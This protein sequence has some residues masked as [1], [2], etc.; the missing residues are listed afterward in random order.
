MLLGNSSFRPVWV[1][2]ASFLAA[3]CLQILPTGWLG[4]YF[5]P[6]WVALVLI[7]WCFREPERMGPGV[8][9]CGGLLLDIV[10]GGILGRHALAKTIVGF[11]SHRI[12]LR[13]RTYPLWQQSIAVAFLI[14]VDTLIQ[15][16]VRFLI[17]EPMMPLAGWLT[18]LASMLMWPLMV[19]ILDHRQR[20]RR[21]R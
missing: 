3:A 7:Y 5:Q 12:S 4:G 6:D 20:S 10:Q 9:W 19:I 13:I 14:F 8:G 16:L 17:D 21:Y 2:V 11:L 1:V 15:A 18:P